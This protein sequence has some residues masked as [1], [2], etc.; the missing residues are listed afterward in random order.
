MD[1]DDKI[2]K[3][4]L[5]QSVTRDGETVHIDIYED[6]ESGWVLEIVDT[7]NNSTT[8]NES[9]ETDTSALKE[10]LFAIEKEGIHSF[11]G[12]DTDYYI[13]TVPE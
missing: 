7:N 10:A 12:R 5:C 11:I 8:W 13:N 3:S 2:K 4:P 1:D 6:G 9:F